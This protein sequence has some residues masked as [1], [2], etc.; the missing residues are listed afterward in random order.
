MPRMPLGGA[1]GVSAEGERRSM[2][3]GVPARYPHTAVGLPGTGARPGHLRVTGPRGSLRLVVVLV[4]VRLGASCWSPVCSAGEAAWA[5]SWRS[6]DTATKPADGKHV[7][8]Q[9]AS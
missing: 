1:S 4:L 8:E 6:R 2:P 7:A 3:R 9:I 5:A